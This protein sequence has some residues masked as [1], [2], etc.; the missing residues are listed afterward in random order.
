M[1]L[2]AHVSGC[3]SIREFPQEQIDKSLSSFPAILC[4]NRFFSASMYLKNKEIIKNCV[5]HEEVWIGND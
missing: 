4:F 3:V 2:L 5:I 1:Q